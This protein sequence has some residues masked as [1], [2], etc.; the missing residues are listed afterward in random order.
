MATPT[1]RVA[2]VAF[3]DVQI[4]DV[5]GP[6]EVFAVAARVARQLRPAGGI[7]YEVEVLAAKPGPV[8]TQSGLQLVADRS[9][10]TVRGGIDT[11][12]VAGGMGTRRAVADA[13]L[14]AWLRRIAPRVRRL[15]SV[16]SGT[17]V[18]AEAGLLDGRRATSNKMYF[19][20][21]RSQGERVNW[22]TAA[23]WVEDGPF[24]TSSGVSAGTDMALAVIARLY[25]AERAEQIAIQTE[26]T[27]HRDASDDPFARYLDQ[28]ILPPA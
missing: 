9:W 3:P 22:V 13:A 23:R 19:Q 16:C 14:L 20:L 28:G 8:R 17:F 4:L 12:L 1:R 5:T 15:G 6:L 18:L 27:W 25:G 21:A 10:G 26:Y 7:P 11:L 2:V 24:A